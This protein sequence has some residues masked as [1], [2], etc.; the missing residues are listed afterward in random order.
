MIGH[1]QSIKIV[2]KSTNNLLKMI[3]K[4]KRTNNYGLKYFRLKI[5]IHSKMRKPSSKYLS[6]Y[7][8]SKNRKETLLLENTHYKSKTN[9]KK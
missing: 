8:L 6:K 4:R 3:G 9:T 2:E 5:K 1:F 7:I